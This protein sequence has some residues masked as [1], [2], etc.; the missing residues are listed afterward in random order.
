MLKVDFTMDGF[1]LDG[2][3]MPPQSV[4]LKLGGNVG[5]EA[6]TGRTRESRVAAVIEFFT[7]ISSQIAELALLVL[8]NQQPLGTPLGGRLYFTV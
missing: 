1:E 4:N 6:M 3:S 8:S 7:I 5:L 2:S